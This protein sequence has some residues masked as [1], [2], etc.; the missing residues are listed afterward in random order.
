MD[1]ERQ[2]ALSRMKSVGTGAEPNVAFVAFVRRER[3][4]R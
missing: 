3:G 4:R 2:V 1:G